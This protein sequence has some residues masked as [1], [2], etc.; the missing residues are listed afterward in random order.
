MFA[1]YF[2]MPGSAIISTFAPVQSAQ[3]T[4][5]SCPNHYTFAADII[6]GI[7][8]DDTWRSI[9]GQ[10]FVPMQMDRP[11]D[12]Q[13]YAMSAKLCSIN[14]T[15]VDDHHGL[16]ESWDF[17]ADTFMV[18][19][20]D[21][22]F[23]LFSNLFSFFSST[24]SASGG[25]LTPLRLQFMLLVLYASSHSLFFDVFV[26]IALSCSRLAVGSIFLYIYL[27]P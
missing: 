23:S 4:P 19:T 12:G 17:E 13:L 1:C 5:D 11:V 24:I 14:P 27:D 7:G 22:R 10:F 6:I 18:C 16:M 15:A 8:E 20:T 26:L 2:S 3:N 21:L 25:V 9:P